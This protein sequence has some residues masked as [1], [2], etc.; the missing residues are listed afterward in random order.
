MISWEEFIKSNILEFRNKFKKLSEE[1]KKL[2]KENKEIFRRSFNKPCQV[3]V[4][5]FNKDYP[6]CFAILHD[7]K[8]PDMLK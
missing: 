4:F 6:T 1:S 5:N 2:V 8:H 7:A 3:L